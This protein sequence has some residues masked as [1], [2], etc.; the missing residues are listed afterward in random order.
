[1]LLVP[2]RAAAA[3]P[4]GSRRAYDYSAAGERYSLPRPAA[5]PPGFLGRVAEAAGR[6]FGRGA[7][8]RKETEPA[9]P[10]PGD[11]RALRTKAAKLASETIGRQAIPSASAGR[12]KARTLATKLASEAIG[13]PALPS[14][15][16]PGAA[17]GKGRRGEGRGGVEAKGSHASA[18][19]V[20]GKRKA[21]PGATA[22]R[23]GRQRKPK[24]KA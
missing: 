18:A 17:G 16:R 21:T 10:A 12:P 23:P 5:K 22:K 2:R 7:P 1:F 24:G 8:T 9:K 4:A 19:K 20:A 6:A 3:P 14:E 13:R 15:A 11:N